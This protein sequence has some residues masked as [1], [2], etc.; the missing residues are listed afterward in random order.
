MEGA[1]SRKRTRMVRPYPVHT[2]EV[3]AA[4]ASKIQEV[5]AGLPFDR[6]LL[7]KELGTTPA[8]SSFTMKLNSSAKYGLTQGGYN[9]DRI[10]LTPRGGSVAAPTRSGKRRHALVEA[11]LEPE[12]F[13]RFY[14][15]LDGKRVPEDS[16]AQN[17]LQRELGVHGSLTGECLRTIKANGLFVGFLRDAEGSLHVSLSGD[18]SHEESK[19]GPAGQQELPATGV[20]LPFD[21]D[22]PEGTHR[23]PAQDSSAIFIGHAGSLDVVDFLKT[24]LDEFEIPY[25]VA[26]SDFADRLPVTNE[27]SKEM[28]A[29]NAAILIFARPSWAQVSGGR[30]ISSAE[31]MLYQLGAASVLYGERVVCLAE[32]GLEEGAPGAGYG[33]FQF[34]REQLSDVALPL[35]AE[36]RHIGAI[37]VRP[38]FGAPPEEE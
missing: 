28:R 1:Q 18:H 5:N 24:V 29:C 37:D 21:A 6:V 13:K 9:D 33:T 27:V 35:L 3:A 17:V 31:V 12:L 20:V 38:Q 11:A 34:D 23:G 7:A 14:Q 10:A 25:R 15:I 30:E 19:G 4:I 2:L 8:S 32:G 26:E 16:Y 22:R 36:L